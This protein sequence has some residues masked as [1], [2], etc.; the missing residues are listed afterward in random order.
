MKYFSDYPEFKPNLTPRQIFKLGSFGGTYWREI[1][2]KVTGKIH[3][4]VYMKY[5]KDWFNGIEKKKLI[6]DWKCYDKSINKYN[7]RVGSTLELWESK[8]WINKKHP[9]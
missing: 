8:N 9:Y 1:K 3:K 2:S 6:T 4:N 7:V 5:P